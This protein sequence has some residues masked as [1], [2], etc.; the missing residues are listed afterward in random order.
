MYNRK[1]QIQFDFQKP[2]RRDQVMEARNT[3]LSWCGYMVRHRVVYEIKY[4][5][6][7]KNLGITIL[8][9]ILKR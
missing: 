7:L 3:G 4:R 8:T 5:Q 6:A 1:V 2:N 9:Q